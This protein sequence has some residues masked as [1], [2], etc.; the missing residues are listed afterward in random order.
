[1]ITF[2]Q[3]AHIRFVGTVSRAFFPIPWNLLQDFRSVILQTWN[4]VLSFAYTTVEN[5]DIH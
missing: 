5:V 3:H 1:M 2:V 4:W